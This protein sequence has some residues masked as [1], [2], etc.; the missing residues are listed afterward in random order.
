MALVDYTLKPGEFVEVFEVLYL[1]EQQ[2]NGELFVKAAFNK[3]RSEV[4]FQSNQ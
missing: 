4:S 2:V 3:G 1:P